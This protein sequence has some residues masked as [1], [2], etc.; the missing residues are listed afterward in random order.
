MSP[1]AAAFLPRRSLG[2]AALPWLSASVTVT[3]LSLAV[4]GTLA[5]RSH[6]LAHQDDAMGGETVIEF[7]TLVTQADS[8]MRQASAD[9]AQPEQQAKPKLEE[10]LSRQ[11]ETPDLPTEQ[12]SPSEAEAPDLRMAPERTA[13][14][15]EV[16]PDMTQATEAAEAQ[17]QIA[18]HEASA[19]A[20]SSPEQRAEQ[21]EERTSAPDHGNAQAADRRI[22]AWQR[23]MF[24]H[25][26]RFKTYPDEAR[27][28]NIRGEIVVAFGLDRTGRVTSVRVATTSGSPALD[29]AALEVLWHASP[30]PPPPADVRGDV[31][32]L[33]L[34]M[35]YQLR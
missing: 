13:R 15:A 30:L 2:V 24:A 32:E 3:A 19:A 20:D 23:A 25:I 7:A 4:A 31:V 18:R 10:V 33:L 35:R 27:K 14:D 17:E 6:L 9:A 22:E 29:K 11:Q 5:I 1:G 26:G 34:P 16:V 12:A 8:P 21:P 28:R